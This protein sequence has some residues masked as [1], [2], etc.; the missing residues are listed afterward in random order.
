M[1]GIGFTLRRLTQR[2]DLLGVF[3]GY[4]HSV[5]ISAGP[6]LFTVFAIGGITAV[7]AT[8]ENLH[9]LNS[10]RIVVIYNFAFSLVFSG[11]LIL[12]AT[13]YLADR[14]Y[15][16]N[17]EE[18]PGMLLA[19]Y[20]I[21][22]VIGALTAGPFYGFWVEL[23]PGLRVAAIANY[24]LV[25]GI[26]VASVFL[27]T[28]KD[29]NSVT[30]TFALG[31]AT[32]FG[33]S[34]ALEGPLG[35]TGVMIGFNCGLGVILF[36]LTARIFA[37]YPYGVV[38]PFAFLGYFKRY[39]DLALSGL[40]Y[41]LAVWA[42]KWVMWF[43]PEREELPSGMISFP[44]YDS[45]MFLA[46]LTIVPALAVFM[47]AIETRFFER[48]QAFY[49]DIQKH[50]TLD[51][52]REN[53]RELIATLLD[54][55][56]SVVVLQ[57]CICVTAILVS[58]YLFERLGVPISQIGIFRLGVLGAM[59]HVLLLFVSI[60]LAYFDLR[61]ILLLAHSVFLVVSVGVSMLTLEWGFAWYGYGYV[62]A[63]IVALTVAYGLLARELARLP[64][65]AFVKS[66]ASIP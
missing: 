51:R 49:R 4:G 11:S 60:V 5:L 45:A 6:W 54:S 52:I 34:I 61:K 55:S 8:P 59:F 43:S 12:V 2:D 38:R 26:W 63:S 35:A 42:D 18:G 21:L 64:Y 58:P 37:E 17:V 15:L 48:Y 33:A 40:V 65:L 31:M 44:D 19:S 28:L 20:A 46:Y 53:H 66:N 25:S 39:W 24:Q 22:F 10:F 36:V 29:F 30:G 62:A 3:E 27:T 57:I 14:I 41:N 50:A 32:A 23:A 9:A 56:R 47:V 13:R 7:A 16:R 1:A